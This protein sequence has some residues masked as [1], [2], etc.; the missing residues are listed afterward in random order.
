MRPFHLSVVLW[1]SLLGDAEKFHE[2]YEPTLGK[3]ALPPIMQ[4]TVIA[5]WRSVDYTCSSGLPDGCL[6]VLKSYLGSSSRH[7][8]LQWN[9]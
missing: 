9:L 5:C 8:Y 1:R 6:P 4:L 7:A 3:H 2:D